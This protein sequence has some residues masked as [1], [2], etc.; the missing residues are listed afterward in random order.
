MKVRPALNETV[1]DRRWDL[2][3]DKY[4]S[5]NADALKCT[6]LVQ[7]VAFWRNL[8]KIIGVSK[9]FVDLLRVVDTE[10]F[11]FGRVYWLMSEAIR[12]IKEYNHFSSREKGQLVAVANAR[13]RQMHT[14]LHGAAFALDPRFQMYNQPAN[15]EVMANF[16]KV[17]LQILPGDEGKEAFHQRVNF[18]NR[19]GLFGDPWHLDA[20]KRVSAPIWWKEYGGETVE[21]QHVATRVLSVA[22]SSGSCE[23]NWSAFDFVHT[24][25]RNRLNPSRAADLVYV[26]CNMRLL[27]APTCIAK[28]AT[29]QSFASF[30]TH[31]ALVEERG[32]DDDMEWEV[33][34]ECS[35]VN[36]VDDMVPVLA[37][38]TSQALLS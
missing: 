36:E 2:W 25:R 35:D 7:S 32:S 11:V 26:F 22:A 24:K 12:Q 27:H 20:I 15:S 38:D 1:A 10:K 31:E 23:R 14:P 8:E 28:R 18:A 4:P 6:Q 3:V 19:M 17:C 13:W 21:L 9:P 16:K 5:Y 33:A 30:Q 29:E 37:D 34:S